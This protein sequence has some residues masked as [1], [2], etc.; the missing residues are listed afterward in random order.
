MT[1]YILNND[2]NYDINYISYEFIINNLM[3]TPDI[4]I[5]YILYSLVRIHLITYDEY[6]SS[7]KYIYK[8]IFLVVSKN[9]LSQNDIDEFL[10][11]EKSNIR[12][13]L[14][15]KNMMYSHNVI[16]ENILNAFDINML[17]LLINLPDITL[18]II[19]NINHQQLLPNMI[20]NLTNIIEQIEEYRIIYNL[21]QQQQRKI[22]RDTIYKTF[23]RRNIP[24]DINK[25]LDKFI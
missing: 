18:S 8:S 12:I 19:K 25:Y 9:I 7:I 11:D 17:D 14:T 16:W 24:S 22:E 5:D 23:Y 2:K 6:L 4:M 21:K 15:T 13:K 3:N 1:S 10:Q 20:V